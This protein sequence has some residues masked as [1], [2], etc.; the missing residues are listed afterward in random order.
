[1][2]IEKVEF[3]FPHEEEGENKFE[4]EVEGVAGRENVLEKDKKDKKVETKESQTDFFGD[5]YASEP[6]VEVV[7]DTPK[8]DQNRKFSPPP[9][10]LTDEE[11]ENYSEKVKKRIKHFSKGY[12]DER[13]VKEQALREKEEAIEY[14]KKI[15]VENR[16]LQGAAEKNRATM[17]EQAKLTVGNEVDAAKRK[18]KE[19][20]EAGESDAVLS[21]TE[22]LTAAK[23]RMEKINSVKLPP[24]QKEKDGVKVSQESPTAPPARRVVDPRDKEWAAKNPWFGEKE[25]VGLEMTGF[26]LG[27]HQ[28][29]EKEGITAKGNPEEYYS[30]V[31]TRM[32]EIFPAQFDDSGSDEPA[33]R[34]RATNVVAAATRSTAP[35]KVVLTKTQVALANRL[36]VPLELYAKK[37]A[38]ESR[39]NNG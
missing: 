19:A 39:K 36:G 32:R 38:E 13:R 35:R 34:K 7:D 29:L 28:R 5:T 3:E 37:A 8:A 23:I 9:E 1:M 10:Q 25:G 14:A 2:A 31:D 20:Y 18:Y 33:Q 15:T 21:A 27:M 24:L 11:L 12:H 6:G 16:Q 4:I 22:A 17:V 30:R 26:A